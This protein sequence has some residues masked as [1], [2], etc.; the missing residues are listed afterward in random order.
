MGLFDNLNLFKRSNTNASQVEE[1]SFTGAEVSLNSLLDNSGPV[2]SL[3]AVYAA[4]EMISNALAELPILIKVDGIVDTEHP[5]NHL[6]CNNLMS[7]YVLIKQL[8]WDILIMNGNA[9]LYIRRDSRG[10]PKEL[11]YCK[12]ADTQIMYNEST[13]DLYYLNQKV[14][15]GR[16]EPKD[17]IHLYKNSQDGINGRSIISYAKKV[18]DLSKYTDATASNYYQSG[19][20]LN[21][22]LT[23][24]GNPSQEE[25]EKIRMNWKRLH[26]ADGNS[27]L[28]I[29]K[30][31]MNY[32]SIG[33]SAAESQMLEA[34]L[35]NVSEIARF[36]NISPVLLGDLTKSSYSTI[37]AA[38]LEFVQH[39]LYPFIVMFEEELNR[40]LCHRSNVR[41]DFDE[42]FLIKSDKAVQANYL[43]TLVSGGIMSINEA[44]ANLGLNPIEG[45]DKV[46]IPF[47]DISQNIIGE[48]EG[49]TV[50]QAE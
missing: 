8:V 47:T 5:F 17:M 27:G 24:T 37:E 41:I 40:K 6:F 36:F 11:I 4:V 16:I 21:G 48:T 23:I 42:S 46:I 25:V 20:N 10:V 45:G 39:T 7:K 1:R 31:N 3:S 22:I 33:Q 12:P 50:A 30:G 18:F 28:A 2:T 13:R 32:Q 29:L 35:F 15:K 14:A 26:G 19:C 34:R 43:N 9:L 49:D 44:R 38:Q